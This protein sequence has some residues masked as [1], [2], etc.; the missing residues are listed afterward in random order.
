M[1][2]FK[3]LL[4]AYMGSFCFNVL[5]WRKLP[6]T[7]FTMTGQALKT[8]C[9]TIQHMIHVLH[10]LD[11]DTDV[12]LRGP[13][14]FSSNMNRKQVSHILASV[15][16]NLHPLATLDLISTKLSAHILLDIRDLFHNLLRKYF[17]ASRATFAAS[18]FL[19]T[20]KFKHPRHSLLIFFFF[21]TSYN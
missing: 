12:E 1:T 4:L 15:S 16:V 5:L 3:R 13:Q 6:A 9:C 18:L 20:T 10:M 8:C 7:Y 11:M 2:S 21:F 17:I 19:G 14:C